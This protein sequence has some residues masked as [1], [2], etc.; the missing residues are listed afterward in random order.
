MNV[1]NLSILFKHLLEYQESITVSY[2]IDGI[3]SAPQV[4]CKDNIK[5]VDWRQILRNLS[6][7]EFK[8][9]VL[10]RLM[11]HHAY[12]IC[13]ICGDIIERKDKLTADHMVCKRRGGPD[14]LYNLQ[15]AH[16]R[17]NTKRGDKP[18]RDTSPYWRHI[19]KGDII[20]IQNQDKR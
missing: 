8:K 9:N 20:R 16:L 11:D 18:L 3:L 17:C 12:P 4:I 10:F 1:K 7:D 14:D 2:R 6:W 19:R 15:P 5:I 13:G